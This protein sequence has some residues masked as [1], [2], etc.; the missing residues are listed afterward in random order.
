ME[1]T[2]LGSPSNGTG[3]GAGAGNGVAP[4][5]PAR[6]RD[7]REIAEARGLEFVELEMYAIDSTVAVLLPE[8][9]CRRHVILPIG[10]S[11]DGLVL[12]MADP[13]NVFALDD[14][15]TLTGRDVKP[16]VAAAE[17][18]ERTI[19]K[20]AALRRQ[21]DLLAEA[22]EEQVAEGE[23]D[24]NA[25]GVDDAPVVKLVQAIMMQ[26]TSSRASDVHIE[27]GQDGVRVR[28][29]V[30][31][32]LHEVMDVPKPMQAGLVSRLKIMADLDIAERRLPQD[33][34]ISLRMGS[35][36]YDLRVASLPTVWGEK[37]VARIL[38]KSDALMELVD[39]GFEGR[40]YARYEQAFRKPYG[41]I[42]VTGPT[43]SGKSTTLYATLNVL[44][45]AERN[46]FT[47]ED[48]VE[49]R[50]PGVNQIQ[51]NPRAKLTFASALRSIL[52]A[53]PDIILIG[54]VRDRETAQIAVEAALTGHLVLTTLHTNDAPSAITRLVE[55]GVE[56]FLVAS[57]L[58]AV[59]AQ[60]LAR[61]LCD[62]CKEA[63]QPTKAELDE[64]GFTEAT[65]PKEATFFRPVG[66]RGC[67]N[68]GYHGRM[69]LYEVM[70]MSEKIERLT[71]ERA[72]SDDIRALAMEE[73]MG[74]LRD[75]GLRKAAAGLTSLPEIARVIK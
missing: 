50:L 7:P 37:I 43:G 41:T 2:L 5:R 6:P 31:G 59:V 58:D 26:A 55:M 46:I 23:L 28:F 10:E 74:A 73:G 54:E 44:N 9:L 40:A 13:G 61:R 52:R 3:N 25:V 53:D 17:D 68:T 33:G 63:Y 57:A 69:G 65:L 39:L 21:T 24:P 19:Q 75:D 29:R 20:Y 38:D 8:A 51:V 11:E 4:T 12:A 71:V 15:R 60:R 66:C 64:A 67:A 18:I 70:L 1:P 56:T 45:D 35:K 16:V 72:S 27:P 30:D 32:V 49:Y 36:S 34:R 48:P 22:G 42:L 62:R 47:V 14:V